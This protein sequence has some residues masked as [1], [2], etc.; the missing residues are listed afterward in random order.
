MFE[1][2]TL[3]TFFVSRVTYFTCIL[4]VSCLYY[5]S[6]LVTLRSG[7]DRERRCLMLVIGAPV[8]M[9]CSES[10]SSALSPTPVCKSHSECRIPPL[11]PQAAVSASR[12]PHSPPRPF[13][14]PFLLSHALPPPSSSLPLLPPPPPLSSSPVPRPRTD[15]HH[16][17]SPHTG[18]CRAAQPIRADRGAEGGRGIT[19]DHGVLHPRPQP[20]ALAWVRELG[21][22]IP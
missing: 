18:L 10:A 16:Y 13:S 6:D 22:G 17:H 2:P 21:R 9:P 14:S 11:R 20:P 15:P 4:L 3:N 1:K 5:Q 12:S 19:R 7:T 8:P